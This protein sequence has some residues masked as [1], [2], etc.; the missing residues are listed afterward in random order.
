MDKFMD[1]YWVDIGTDSPGEERSTL[2]LSGHQRDISMINL[3][4]FGTHKNRQ[5]MPFLSIA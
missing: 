1:W 4:Q 2:K 3:M 5:K